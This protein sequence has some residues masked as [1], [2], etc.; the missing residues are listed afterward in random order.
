MLVTFEVLNYKD[1][2][3]GVTANIL[4]Y[5]NKVIGGDICLETEEGFIHGLVEGLE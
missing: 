4:L 3:E 1:V 5:K 2:P